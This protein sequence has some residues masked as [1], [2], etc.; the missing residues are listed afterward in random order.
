MIPIIATVIISSIRVNPFFI[1]TPSSNDSLKMEIVNKN[2]RIKL[3]QSILKSYRAALT[4][5]LLNYLQ[6]ILRI[7]ARHKKTPK[8][9]KPKL[10][11]QKIVD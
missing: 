1:Y 5:Q 9:F 2:I 8:D 3:I 6:T 4:M 7:M 11:L 10:V